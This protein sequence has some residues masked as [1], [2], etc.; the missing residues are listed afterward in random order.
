M[1]GV[2]EWQSG[3]PLLLGNVYYSGDIT[4]LKSMVGEKNEQG[5]TYGVDI[6]AFDITGFY[7][8]GVS[9]TEMLRATEIISRQ[10]PQTVRTY[11]VI[12][13]S[14]LTDSEISVT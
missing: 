11:S 2:Y 3:E 12:F 1:Q 5:Q 6:P 13:R 10:I 7:V 4:K 9:R 14:R 8:G